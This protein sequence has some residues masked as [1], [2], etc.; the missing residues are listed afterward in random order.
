M[1]SGTDDYAGNGGK[2]SP[3]ESAEILLLFVVS[4]RS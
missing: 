3:G 4:S 2:F 1:S